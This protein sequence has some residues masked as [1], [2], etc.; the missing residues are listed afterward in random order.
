MIRVF[1]L[2]SDEATEVTLKYYF[3]RNKTLHFFK[4]L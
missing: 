4:L 2:E 1:E 3:Q